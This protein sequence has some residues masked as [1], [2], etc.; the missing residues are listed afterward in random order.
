MPRRVRC[1]A[2]IIALGAIGCGSSSKGNAR[3]C[4]P[5]TPLGEAN[6]SASTMVQP[7]LSKAEVDSLD[8][9]GGW[10]YLRPNT[11]LAEHQHDDGDELIWISCGRGQITVDG[12]TIP[13][14]RGLSHL[15]HQGTLHRIVAEEEGLGIVQVFRPGTPGSRYYR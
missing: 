6:T 7:L 4:F 3:T 12:K 14:A 1:F 13:I 15:I 2:V 5:E 8:L 11:E 9:Y 10:L